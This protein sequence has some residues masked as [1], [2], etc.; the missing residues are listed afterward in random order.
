MSRVGKVPIS[1]PKDVTIKIDGSLVSIKGS[2]GENGLRMPVGINVEL[3]ERSIS[4]N[5]CFRRKTK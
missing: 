4:C 2:K 1:V 5:A 3:K